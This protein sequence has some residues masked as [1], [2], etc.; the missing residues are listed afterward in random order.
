MG[1]NI[2][3]IVKGK[4]LLDGYIKDDKEINEETKA[5]IR[6]KYS[7]EDELKLNRIAAKTSKLSAEFLVYDKYVQACIDEGS[8]KK[9]NAA[10]ELK[11]LTKKEIKE[12]G[13]L[14][15]RIIFVRGK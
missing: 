2:Y 7:L 9:K 8:L 12:K 11:K 6:E 15:K 13:S 1:T 14:G 3:K 10:K 4:P 5:K